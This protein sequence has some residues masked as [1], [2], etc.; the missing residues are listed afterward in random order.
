MAQYWQIQLLRTSD[1]GA[2]NVQQLSLTNE[3]V[4]LKISYWKLTKMDSWL[5]C[6]RCKFC[7]GLLRGGKNILRS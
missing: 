4:E 1:F 6:C 3:I 5:V 7:E 2:F